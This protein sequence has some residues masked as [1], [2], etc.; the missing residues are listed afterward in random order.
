MTKKT[1]IQVILLIWFLAINVA[2]LI[3]SYRLIFFSPQ[4]ENSVGQQLPLS[5]GPPPEPA[6]IAP[7]DPKLEPA[8]QQQQVELYKQRV[9]L[10]TEQIKAYTQ[11]VTAYTQ[12]VAA[13]K[14][15]EESRK[16]NDGTAV[17]ELVVKNSLVTLLGGFAT[18]LISYVFANLGA[19]V[20]DNY[21]RVKNE[22][23]PEPLSLL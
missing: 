4:D 12:H 23:E 13:Y 14:V 3:P 1:V 9:N 7:L 18:A 6:P 8:K 22:K 17:Y 10:Y 11:E 20:V 5:P 15:S 2:I 16:K 21:I 19:G